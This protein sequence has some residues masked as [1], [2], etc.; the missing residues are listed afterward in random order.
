MG[1]YQVIAR[2]DGLT[3]Y[4][5]VGEI[6]D[7]LLKYNPNPSDWQGVDFSFRSVLLGVKPS[8][9]VLSK[10]RLAKCSAQDALTEAN[11]SLYKARLSFNNAMRYYGSPVIA[12]QQSVNYA[13]NL[14]AAMIR[15]EQAKQA[16]NA[17]NKAWVNARWP[18][19]A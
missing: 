15:H 6:A 19:L 10:T 3:S 7:L 11:E 14:F 17:A 16:L 2:Q 13:T 12:S 5:H 1:G 4:V 8:S 18:E 9:D